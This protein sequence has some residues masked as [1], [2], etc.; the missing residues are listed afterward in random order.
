[1]TNYNFLLLNL[2]LKDFR[3]RYRNMSL[4]IF[5]SLLNPLIMMLMMTFVFTVLSRSKTPHFQVFVLCAL[6]PFNFFTLAWATSTNSV[7]ENQNLIKRQ[8]FPREILPVSTVLANCLHF[9]IQ[10]ALLLI[11]VLGSG[12]GVNRY[13]LLLPVVWGLEVVFTCGMGLITSALDVYFRDVRYIVESANRILFWAVPIFY[14]FAIIP[15]KYHLIYQLNPISAVVL[16]TRNILLEAKAP[17]FSLLWKLLVV[18]FFC[19]GV[20]AWLFDRLE[21]KFADLV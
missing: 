11:F 13:W 7:V 1:M 4:G 19:L 9:L 15:Q 18:S 3:V 6:V 2:V 20:G 14:S 16:A 17:P 21:R 12:Y 5:W 10:I 8:R